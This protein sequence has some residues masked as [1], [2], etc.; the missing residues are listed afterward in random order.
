MN[1][2]INQIEFVIF[3]V[4]TTGLNPAMGDRI[5]EI[6][7]IKLKARKEVSRFYSLVNPARPMPQAAYDIHHIS[8]HML[9][10]APKGTAVLMDFLEFIKGCVLAGYNVSFD[11]SFIENELHMINKK[12]DPRIPIIDILSTTKTAGFF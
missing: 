2:P 8:D 4:E 11:L 10:D 9:K 1:K 6:A 12:L 5:C 3:D 7:A